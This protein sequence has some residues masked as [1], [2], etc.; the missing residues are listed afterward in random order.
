MKRSMFVVL[1]LLAVGSAIALT[2]GCSKQTP[3]G[4]DPRPVT[5]E[6]KAAFDRGGVVVHRV[7]GDPSRV[8]VGY[9]MFSTRGADGPSTRLFTFA[10]ASRTLTDETL[11]TP[12]RVWKVVTALS[13]DPAVGVKGEPPRALHASQPVVIDGGGDP[14]NP[15]SCPCCTRVDAT[16]CSC[17]WGCLK[18]CYRGVFETE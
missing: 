7:A 15:C 16:V 5:I 8:A 12:V 13:F 10:E 9:L 18:S 1:A 14:P 2:G 4:I 11:V 6:S 17:T 3:T